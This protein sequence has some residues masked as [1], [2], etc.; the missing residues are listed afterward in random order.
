[1]SPYKYPDDS[2]GYFNMVSYVTCMICNK[3]FKRIT[4][5]HLKQHNTTLV[6]YMIDHPNSTLICDDT[7]NKLRTNTL[8]H[9][10]LVHGDAGE[11]RYEECC[12]RQA[13]TNT[14]EYKRATYGWTREQFNDYNAKR[15]SSKDTFVQR[16]GYQEGIK[17]WD[18][19]CAHQARAGVTREWFIEKLS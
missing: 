1:M 11:Q 14:Y 3:Q 15:R 9:F 6:Q 12:K 13:Y 18:D 19:Y 4:H 17:K 16:Y 8:D 5:K 10:K 2:E 7:R